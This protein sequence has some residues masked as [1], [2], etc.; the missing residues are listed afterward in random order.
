MINRLNARRSAFT[1][2]VLGWLMVSISV[3]D[4]EPKA[5]ND[6]KETDQ[7]LLDD[8]QN[9]LLEGIELDGPAADERKEHED[10]SKGRD[11]GPKDGDELRGGADEDPL[12]AIGRRMLEVEKRLAREDSSVATQAE[13]KKILADLKK[14]IDNAQRQK[15]SP[16]A[17]S[18]SN[19]K[20]T[21][22]KQLTRQPGGKDDA[23]T[24]AG[25]TVESTERLGKATAKKADP[26]EI[27]ERIEATWGVL[28]EQVREQMR[29]AAEDDFLGDFEL[30]IENYFKRLAERGANST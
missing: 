10:P 7:Q 30:M 9:D 13:Q 16:S 3:A 1:A 19:G 21:A 14:L 29:H 28:P 11:A 6:Q 18:G 22:P 12:T 5:T 26:K 15:G 23:S 8:L 4:D 24:Q 20:T 25:A 27:R 2:L 17:S